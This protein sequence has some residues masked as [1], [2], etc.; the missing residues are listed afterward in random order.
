MTTAANLAGFFAAHAIWCVSDATTTDPM[1]VYTTADDQ[2]QMERFV[3]YDAAAA[4]PIARRKMESNEMDATDAAV[5]YDGRISGA[6]GKLNAIIIE[7]RAHFFPQSRAV[8]A[9]PYTP[10]AS[11]KFLV[12]KPKLLLWENCDDFDMDGM[13]QAFFEGVD[14][15]EKGSAIWNESLDES[16]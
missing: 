11:G 4:V 1:L 14:S 15:H 6:E 16:K 13:F 2:R 10:K 9:V 12:H 3:G 5:L 8:F 7:M